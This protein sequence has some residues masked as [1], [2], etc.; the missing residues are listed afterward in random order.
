MSF[1]CD[2][3]DECIASG[4][5]SSECEDLLDEDN[6]DN[7]DN[8]NNNDNNNNDPCDQCHGECAYDDSACHQ[9]CENTVCENDNDDG[10]L[11]ALEIFAGSY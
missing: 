2:S 6:H 7:Y 3:Y 1:L 9:N 10:F 11:T 4:K 8:N 5:T